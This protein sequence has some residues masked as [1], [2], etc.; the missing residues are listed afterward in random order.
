MLYLYAIIH[1]DAPLPM[2][3]GLDGVVPFALPCG[4]LAA[5][6]SVHPGAAPQPTAEYLWQHEAVI[7]ALMDDRATLPAR[8]GTLLPDHAAVCGA[9]YSHAAELEADLV[10]VGGRVELGVRVLMS[11]PER[12]DAARG[13][14]SEQPHQGDN[15]ASAGRN[16]MLVRLAEEQRTQTQRQHARALAEELHAALAVGADESVCRVLVTEQM[17][18]AGAYLVER[19]A[20]AGFQ[21]RCAALGTAYPALQLLGTG[22]WPPYHFVSTGAASERA[23]SLIAEV[24]N[25]RI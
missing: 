18:L 15:A 1:A 24:A 8:F 10:R 12:A 3:R 21:R 20:V 25:E 17:I 11:N 2:L 4:A 13:A 16:Y 19:A 5:V 6:V 22:P 7:E 14:G 23:Q 9:L